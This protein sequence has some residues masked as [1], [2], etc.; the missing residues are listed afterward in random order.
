VVLPDVAVITSIELEHTHV[1]G[2]TLAEIAGE[3][4]G[5]VKHGVP[6]VT[7][8][9]DDEPLEPIEQKCDK[10]RSPLW[11]IGRDF[12][13]ENVQ[14]G[15][16]GQRF[17]LILGDE[18]GGGRFDRLDL[19]LAGDAQ[20][21]NAALAVI[22]AWLI[23]ERFDAISEPAIRCGLAAARWPGRLELVAGQ[24]GVLLDVAHTPASARQLRRYLDRFFRNVPKTLALGMLRDKR[25]AEVAAEFA[26]CFDRIVAAPVKWFRTMDADTLASAFAPV[27]NDVETAPTICTAVEHLLRTTPAHGLVVIAGSLFSVGEAKRR[28]GWT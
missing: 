18:L 21:V 15:V 10:L 2:D 26:P 23:R 11:R 4:A 16:S 14:A 24:P 12:S 25:V 8:V 3:K 22:A 7:A 9:A 17:D 20:N 28:F 5:I 27:R 6:T 19:G 1:L 13:I